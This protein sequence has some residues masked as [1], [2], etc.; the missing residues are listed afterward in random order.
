MW[1][2][3]NEYNLK[4]NILNIYFKI[5]NNELIFLLKSKFLHEFFKNYYSTNYITYC[6]I[7]F[8]FVKKL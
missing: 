2:K 6:I 7:K 8:I 1:N 3:F 5:I 4:W